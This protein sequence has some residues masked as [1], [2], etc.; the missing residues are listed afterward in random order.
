MF[1]SGHLLAAE[2]YDSESDAD[3]HY[4]PQI[5]EGR[6]RRVEKPEPAI[7]F[8]RGYHFFEDKFSVDARLRGLSSTEVSSIFASACYEHLK[9]DYRE[10][11]PFNVVSIPRLLPSIKK[12]IREKA[13]EFV[14]R[15]Y[16]KEMQ[17]LKQGKPVTFDGHIFENAYVA[18]HYLYVKSYTRFIEELRKRP[19][20]R[21][22]ILRDF[23]ATA[24]MIIS[25]AEKPEHAIKY[26]YGVKIEG[27]V[28]RPHFDTTGKPS[29]PYLGKLQLIL[30]P[31]RDLES[32]GIFR[33]LEA[34]AKD[35]M[36]VNC[37]I[38]HEVEADFPASISKDYVVA[39]MVIRV[40]NFVYPWK[41]SHLQ[42]YGLTRSTYDSIRDRILATRGDYALQEGI[43]EDLV[44]HLINNNYSR[45][46]RE[47]NL[48]NQALRL[49][50]DESL[51]RGYSL[52]YLDFNRIPSDQIVTIEQA[53]EL[54]K[55]AQPPV[56]TRT[57]D[58][59][60]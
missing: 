28:L 15:G 3:W 27:K 30:A 16:K 19:E 6:T 34:Y 58:K 42:K 22:E 7:L 14:S 4:Q 52:K 37:R 44:Q 57:M 40:P 10:A 2:G 55:V 32:L 9:L 45:T 47:T 8:C 51:V 31:H 21:E 46:P 20:E 26:A 18:M 11:E 41:N 53:N 38:K 13:L 54:R 5:K 25:V 12:E 33:V 48:T 39:Q 60:S 49:A 56:I 43:Y 29:N 35:Q 59:E 36:P 23:S 17:K 24:N 1:T 50:V